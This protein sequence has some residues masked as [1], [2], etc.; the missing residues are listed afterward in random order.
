MERLRNFF[1]ENVNMSEGVAIGGVLISAGLIFTGIVGVMI[2]HG[3]VESL[4]TI[5]LVVGFILGVIAAAFVLVWICGKLHWYYSEWK[6]NRRQKRYEAQ[7]LAIRKA[8]LETHTPVAPYTP[9]QE[10]D[11]EDDI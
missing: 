8:R 10:G 6:W 2:E 4:T 3:F 5:S 1:F 11:K 9:N 7:Q